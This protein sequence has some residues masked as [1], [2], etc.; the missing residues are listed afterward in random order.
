MKHGILIN[1]NKCHICN[2]CNNNDIT[3]SINS[4]NKLVCES[5]E[6]SKTIL[7]MFHKILNRNNMRSNK[8]DGFA[9]NVLFPDKGNKIKNCIDINLLSNTDTIKYCRISKLALRYICRKAKISLIKGFCFCYYW[10]HDI[11]YDL[12]GKHIGKSERTVRRYIEEATD[13]LYYNWAVKYFNKII[14]REYIKKH[15]TKFSRVVLDIPDPNACIAVIDGFSI[16]T[17]TPG[18]YFYSKF[19][20]LYPII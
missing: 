13:K 16:E 19:Q 17:E 11:D 9:R 18:E 4:Q 20:Y 7:S 15:T 8:I 5:V 6:Y 3:K 14:S 10:G 2:N 1:D 12:I